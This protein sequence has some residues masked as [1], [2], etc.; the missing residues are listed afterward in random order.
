MRCRIYCKKHGSRRP[1]SRRHT[2][3]DKN[4]DGF[5]WNAE[6][7]VKN[8]VLEGHAH[9]DTPRRSHNESDGQ[10]RQIFGVL[11]E[12]CQGGSCRIL[13]ILA[14]NF[15]QI[16]LKGVHGCNL[17]IECLVMYRRSILNDFRAGKDLNFLIVQ[18]FE[19]AQKIPQNGKLIYFTFLP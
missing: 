15:C 17:I 16:F 14:M 2:A 8:T 19:H 11:K 10:N 9:G 13:Q 3:G 6:S 4:D 7:I 5:T 1:C 18:N 12:A